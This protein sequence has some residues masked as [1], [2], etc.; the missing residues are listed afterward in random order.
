MS[1]SQFNQVS[2]IK[3]SSVYFDGQCVSHTLLFEDGKRKTL[4]VILPATAL[5]SGESY[6]ELKFETHTSERM[7]ITSGEC[8]VRVAGENEFV[9]Y[10][11]GQ[12]FMIGGN[13]SFVIRASDVVDYVCHFE[14]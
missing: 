10:R 7:E 13:S 9:D 4:G 5:A 6:V 14:G 3:K 1:A 11:A 8:S 2:V 12:S